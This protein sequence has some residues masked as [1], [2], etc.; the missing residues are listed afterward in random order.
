[1][2][3]VFI[4]A[5]KIPRER[6]IQ[7]KK[8][9]EEMFTVKFYKGHTAKIVEAETINIFA[10]G[11]QS[12]SDQNPALRT[13]KVREIQIVVPAQAKADVYYVGE[14]GVAVEGYAAEDT[15]YFYDVAFIENSHG[16]TTE[17]VRPY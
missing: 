5:N 16:A 15:P 17:T 7:K 12:G 10:A 14:P 11:A 2:A 4:G 9:E 13:N 6:K 1:M 3:P 8:R